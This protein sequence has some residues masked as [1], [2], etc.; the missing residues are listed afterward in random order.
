MSD[1]RTTP[2]TEAT[3]ESLQRA[4]VFYNDALFGGALCQCLI[5]IQ[6]QD[7]SHGY[8]IGNRFRTKRGKL[9]RDEISLNPEDFARSDRRVLS[10]LVHEMVHLWQHHHGKPG[11]D[12]YHNKEWAS[13]MEEVG[14]RPSHTGRPGGKST[15]YRMSHYIPRTGPF[16]DASRDLQRLGFRFQWV[17]RPRPRRRA[18]QTRARFTCYQCET[19]AWARPSIKLVCGFCG[20]PMVITK[21]I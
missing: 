12:G 9:L 4:F 11:K 15:G 5:T 3:Y 19:N 2:P 18:P 17:A 10:T 13:K 14:L 21:D 20:T 6:D 8:F 7:G 16:V 1:V